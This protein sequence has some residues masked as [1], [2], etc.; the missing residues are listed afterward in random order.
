MRNS[1][2]NRDAPGAPCFT[3]TLIETDKFLASLGWLK[4]EPPLHLP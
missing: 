2:F 4:G 1:R 3:Q